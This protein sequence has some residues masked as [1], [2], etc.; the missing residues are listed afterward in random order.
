MMRRLLC[1][2]ALFSPSLYLVLD[3]FQQSSRLLTLHDSA[4]AVRLGVVGGAHGQVQG[5]RDG[6]C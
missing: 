2:G 6:K 1:P 3:A 5:L 4:G